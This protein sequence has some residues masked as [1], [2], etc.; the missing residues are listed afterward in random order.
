MRN[1]LLAKPML[2]QGPNFSLEVS[3]G[4]EDECRVYTQWFES[5]GQAESTLKQPALLLRLGFDH[6]AE[7]LELCWQQDEVLRLQ[8]DTQSF[9]RLLKA[10]SA[11][12]Q[13]FKSRKGPLNQALGRKTKSIFDATG[14]WGND[15]LLFAEQG[16]RVTTAERH[17]ILAMMLHHAFA[18]L[19]TNRAANSGINIPTLEFGLAD[20]V[21]ERYSSSENDHSFDCVYF[22]PM[23][24]PKRKK[25]AK[26][27][28]QMQFAQ[29]LL[30]GDPDSGRTAA[31]LLELGAPRLVVKRPR[32][33]E[34]LLNNVSHTFSAN[35]VD[36]DV[37][38]NHAK[39]H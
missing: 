9:L 34:P 2:I 15:S 36:Y 38:L 28:K 22:D 29:A 12:I 21:F 35:L 25:S 10:E 24:P 33:A 5:L 1:A 18:V 20:E 37:Y 17:P 8:V 26:S 27:N 3:G 31:R 4:A 16:F 14:G 39:S 11:A 30:S 7:N 19:E 32:Y 23:F 6:A 13:N